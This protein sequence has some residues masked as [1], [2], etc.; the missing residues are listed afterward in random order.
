VLDCI[1]DEHDSG[2]GKP[3]D[4]EYLLTNVIPSIL[5]VSGRTKSACF[6]TILIT[7]PLEHPFLQGRGFV[8]ASQ[9]AKLLPLDSAG[10]YLD[11]AI[12]VVEATE[13]GIP[14]KISAVKAVHK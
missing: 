4:I 7:F 5:N 2:R 14:V 8:F 10:Q 1:E 9:Y 12:Q 13:A 11:A 6:S 3:I